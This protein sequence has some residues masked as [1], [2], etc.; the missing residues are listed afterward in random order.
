MFFGKNGSSDA[1]A[2]IE[3]AKSHAINDAYNLGRVMELQAKFWYKERR[4]E[5][6]KREALGAVDAYEK[7]GA[8]KDVEDCRRIL[9]DIEEQL[10]NLVIS[11]EYI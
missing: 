2:H 4:F 6:A 5:D 10:E 8:S 11:G 3:R 1:H 7:V 9:R